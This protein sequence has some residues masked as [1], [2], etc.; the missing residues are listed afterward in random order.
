MPHRQQNLPIERLRPA[1]PDFIRQQGESP[2]A[3]GDPGD[4]QQDGQLMTTQPAEGSED[5]VGHQFYCDVG[6]GATIVD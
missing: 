3:G 5:E 4:G 1:F 2:H 6:S